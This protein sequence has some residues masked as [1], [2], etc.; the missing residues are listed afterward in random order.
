MRPQRAS[1]SSIECVV[2]I[3]DLP[4]IV[5]D[6]S[7]HINRRDSGSTPV[8]GSSRKTILGLPTSAMPSESFRRVP[9]EKVWAWRSA[10]CESVSWSSILST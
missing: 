7:F 5:V 8:V 10:N 6:I 2:R 9:P 4:C 3:T 1:H